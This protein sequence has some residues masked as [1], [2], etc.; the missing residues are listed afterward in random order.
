MAVFGPL[1]FPCADAKDCES[2]QFASTLIRDGNSLLVGYGVEDCDAFLQRFS[3]DQVLQSLL[4]VS[5]V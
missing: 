5:D 2:I 4:N 1:C 3:L